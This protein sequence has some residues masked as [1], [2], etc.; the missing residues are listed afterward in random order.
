ML[1]RSIFLNGKEVSFS[2]PKDALENGIAMVHQELNQCLERNVIDNLF[3]GRYPVNSMGVIDEG[4]MKKEAAELFR[5]LGMTVNL[6][7]PMG[8]MSVSQRQMCEIAK[9][10]S[11][12]SRVIVLDEPTSSLTV[13]ERSEERRVGK[14]CLRLCR[15]RWS[16]YH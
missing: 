8:R 9:A 13:Q 15:S 7:Q 5:K 3:L 10:I 1:F 6:T 16:P 12:N 11:Y 4:R 14:E 2:G